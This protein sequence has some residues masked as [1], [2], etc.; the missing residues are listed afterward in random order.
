ML[1]AEEYGGDH[2]DEFGGVHWASDPVRVVFLAT[3][4][5][6]RH[7]LLLIP[8]VCSHRHRSVVSRVAVG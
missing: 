4:H 7:R 8:L 2:P 5:L 3:A 6:N 1:A